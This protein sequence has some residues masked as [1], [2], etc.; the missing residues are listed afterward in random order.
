MNE[1]AILWPWPWWTAVMVSISLIMGSLLFGWAVMLRHNRRIRQL[2]RRLISAGFLASAD[3]FDVIGRKNA[4][5]VS[6]S[7]IGVVDLG[8][9]RL[10]SAL[11][12][13]N[14]AAMKSYENRSDQIQFRLITK[15]GAQTR[16]L[17]TQDIVGFA[18]LFEILRRT[19]KRL[20]YISE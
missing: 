7:R 17:V 8:E 9:A 14:I 16:E 13:R 19:A 3:T 2:G 11:D 1:P 15:H 12:L 4:L 5:I 10:V 20:E 6:S 18:K